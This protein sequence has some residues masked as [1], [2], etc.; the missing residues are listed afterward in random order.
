MFRGS[1][2][3]TIDP[4]GRIIVPTRFREVIKDSGTD[5]IMI[6]R[7]DRCLFAYAHDRWEELEQKILHLPEKSEEMRRF[8][9]FFIGGAQ[10]C[11]CDA[12]GRVLIPPFLKQYSELDKDIVL[13]GVLDRFEIW[14]RENWD[15]ENGLQERDM[16]N[17]QVRRE[18]ALLGL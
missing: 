17:E 6:T 13:V 7:M 5:S 9:R 14:S 1:S 11:K 18:I 2:F 4:K 10:D 8:Q 16:A 15:R 12:Q 3:H